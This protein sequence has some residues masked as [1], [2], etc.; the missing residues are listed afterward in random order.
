VSLPAAQSE[1]APILIRED[2]GPVATLTLNR[3]RQLNALSGAMIDAL[4]AELRRLET[5]PRIRVVVLAGSGSAFSAGHDLKELRSLR[6]RE[7]IH[8]IFARCCAVMLGLRRLP[9][10][11]IARIH[12][13]ATAAGCQ[14]VAAADLAVASEKARFAT[15]GINVGLFCGT[16]SVPLTRVVSPKPAIADLAGRIIAQSPLALRRGKELFYRQRGMELADAYALA[17]EAMA[18]NMMAEDAA[19]GIDAFLLK[20]KPVWHGR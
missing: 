15:S 1:M 19:E 6:S 14:L 3:P 18:D 12:G 9:Q 5:D 10:P 4:S 20:R 11:V 16:P 2:R 17:S 8:G 13:I 7:E